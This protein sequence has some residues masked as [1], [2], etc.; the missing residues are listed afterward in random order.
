MAKLLEALL[1]SRLIRSALTLP[2]VLYRSIAFLLGPEEAVRLRGLMTDKTIAVPSATQLSHARLK[3]DCLLM[4]TRR[5]QWVS[6]Q[7]AGSRVFVI[8]SS[9]ASPQ[10]GLQYFVTVEDRCVNPGLLIDSSPEIISEWCV[11]ENM[12]TAVLP[13]CVIGSGNA[14]TAAKCEALFHS[15]MLDC[16]HEHLQE[17][18]TCVLGYCTDF[19]VEAHV[20]EEPHLI[21]AFSVHAHC[22]GCFRLLLRVVIKGLQYSRISAWKIL[23]SVP[24]RC[25]SLQ[26]TSKPS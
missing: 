18:C 14:G 10:G 7:Q 17:Y 3:M 13:P 9:D 16:P 24:A 25:R 4:E 22:F 23:P 2:E 26:L 6:N 11:S 1:L 21:S 12:Q 8:L 15:I 5:T 20:P 19:G